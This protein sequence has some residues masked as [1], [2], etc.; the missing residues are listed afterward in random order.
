[1]GSISLLDSE[2]NPMDDP[3]FVVEGLSLKIDRSEKMMEE[4]FIE[5][6]HYSGGSFSACSR[7]TNKKLPFYVEVCGAEVVK[8]INRDPLVIE[9]FTDI[10]EIKEF[11]LNEMFKVTQ[12]TLGCSHL[13]F[14][15]E[16]N[17]NYLDFMELVYIDESDQLIVD[18]SFLSNPISFDLEVKALTTKGLVESSKTLSFNFSISPKNNPP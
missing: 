17:E 15:L 8:P 3:R 4:I 13:E 16:D 5:M 1:M 18:E 14:S 7:L 2:G 9:G 11:D 10:P 12:E 6:A